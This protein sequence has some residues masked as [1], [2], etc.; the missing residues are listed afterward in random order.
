[1]RYVYLGKH[2]LE[3]YREVHFDL[4]PLEVRAYAEELR[5][6]LPFHRRH[7]LALPRERRN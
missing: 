2:K 1:M 3:H 4:R 6:L 7:L 5:V